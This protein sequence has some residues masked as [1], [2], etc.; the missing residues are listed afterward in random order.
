MAEPNLPAENA[1][2]AGAPDPAEAAAPGAG[3]LRVLLAGGG[4][5]GHINPL[6]A[7]AAALAARPG[8][9]R[10]TAL[11]TAAGLEHTLVPAA[12]YP[13]RIVP[14]V[15]L[16]RRPSLDLLRLPTNLAAAVRAAGEAID[17]TGAQVVVGFG[18]YVA[19]PAYLAA[20]RRGVPVVVHEQNARPGLANRL[21]ARWAAAVA[22]TFPSTP[23]RAAR[24][25]TEVTGLPLRAPVA[26]LVAD[27]HTPETAAARRAAGAAALG[28]DPARPTLLVTGGSLGAQ[29]LNEAVPAAA[30]DLVA[31]GAQVL[32]LTGRGKADPVRAVLAAAGP[33]GGGALP[34]ARV[35]RRD[36]ARLRL[37]RPRAVPLR[38][39]DRRRARRARAARR[40]R[41]A[42]GGQRRAAAQ[43][44]RRRRRRGR[45]ARGRRRPGRRVGARPRPPAARRPRGAGPHGRARPRGPARPTAPPTSRGW[46][47]RPRTVAGDGAGAA[48]ARRGR[49][50]GMTRF[51]LIGIGGAGMSAV[52]ELLLARG[53]AVSGSDQRDSATLARLR[54]LGAQV[55]AG[56]DA[57]H[58]PAD[59]AL[60]VSTAV[61]ETNPELAVARARGQRVLHR[62]EALA[63]AAEGR[64]FVAVAG[65]HGKTSTSAMLAVALR[66]AGQDPSYAIGGTVL[67]LG[68]GAHLGA[69]RAFVAEADESDGSFLN[70]APRVALVTNI[71]PDHLDHYGSE[72]AFRRAFEEFAGRIVPGGLLVA[73]ADDPGA[74][75]LARHA[76]DA[77]CGCAPTAP[78]RPPLPDHV[79]VGDRRLGAA[80]S[81]AVLATAQGEVPLE[82]AVGGAHMLLNAAGAWSAGVELGV[83]PGDMA[84][85]AGR[86]HRHGPPLRGQGQRRRG[87]GGRRLR[88]PPHRGR[89]HAA[90]RPARRRATGGCSPCS[91][92]TCTRA[93]RTSPPSSPTR[94]PWR[95][96]PSSPT[97]TPPARTRCPA[98]TARSSPPRQPAGGREQY[99]ADRVEAAR[100]VADL[101]RPG[102]LVLT[103]GAGD[104]TELGP[105]ILDQLRE[106]G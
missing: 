100:A 90:H 93:R 31:A 101:A 1:V 56:H 35:P 61:R 21:G 43:R 65:A 41:P 66:A 59:A 15:P 106:R 19:T 80:G 104:V 70:Y 86:L 11:G 38:R 78:A 84:A 13:L 55:F 103:L 52:A 73:C 102:D 23:L 37:R 63:L 47:P 28:L 85:G 48:A 68:T 77:G 7:T 12:G 71:E 76:A 95:T 36:G 50:A 2:P 81:R 26:A 22:L 24:G 32:H 75:A 25:R 92:R 62:S 45:D 99:V 8:G 33:A 18:G 64:D 4:T 51:H 42:A 54:G 91:S 79:H 29:R 17:A 96:R 83:A 57:A 14:R 88:P 89:R 40:V 30:A 82:L 34:R 6:L 16:P 58:V 44:R 94:W 74:L 39:R 20:R 10:V 60:V 72:A 69:G 5:A 9:A 98:S 105:V 87:A 3:A 67:A 49:E 46:S 97:S 27:R 53:H